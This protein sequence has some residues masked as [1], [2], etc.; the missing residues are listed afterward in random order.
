MK[1]IKQNPLW[2]FTE[3]S[4]NVY[5]LKRRNV[6]FYYAFIL[7][8]VNTIGVLYLHFVSGERTVMVSSRKKVSFGLILRERYFVAIITGDRR[9]SH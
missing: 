3:V 7:L 5:Q 9:I 6:Q 8:V 1:E 2:P 4:P